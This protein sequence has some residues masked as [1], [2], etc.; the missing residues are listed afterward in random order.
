[1]KNKLSEPNEQGY[2]FKVNEALTEYAHK[3]QYQ[4]ADRYLPSLKVTVL[5]AWKEGKLE[6]YLLVDEET[7]KA[8]DEAFGFEAAACSLDKYKLLVQY[9]EL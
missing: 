5:E 3:K 8:V 4:T 7:N 6:A 9:A 1:M 2:Q